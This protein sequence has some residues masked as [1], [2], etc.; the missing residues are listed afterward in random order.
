M[1]MLFFFCI[2]YYYY[3]SSSFNRSGGSAGGGAL[4]ALRALRL[5][6]LVRLLRSWQSMMQLLQAIVASITD[7]GYFMLLMVLFLFITALAANNVFRLKMAHKGVRSRN[8]FDTFGWAMVTMFQVNK[9]VESRSRSC[10][11]F[12]QFLSC[13][14]HQFFIIN[15]VQI[16]THFLFFN[17]SLSASHSG[18]DS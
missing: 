18:H 14:F 1:R 2:H 15:L 10:F 11:R 3:Y 12:P 8:H 4:S 6:R 7:L 16:C 5:F 9:D 17:I 13:P